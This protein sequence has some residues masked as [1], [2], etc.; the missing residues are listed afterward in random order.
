[1]AASGFAGSALY[2]MTIPPSAMAAENVPPGEV[3]ATKFILV[4]DAGKTQAM[5]GHYAP[6]YATGDQNKPDV[7]DMVGLVLYGEDGKP[8]IQLGRGGPV[9]RLEM[10]GDVGWM[11]LG[12][13]PDGSGVGIWV[14]QDRLRFGFGMQLAGNGGAVVNDLSGKE[15][16]GIG[17]PAN[18]GLSM[19]FKDEAGADIWSAP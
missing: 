8:S 11:T 17:M 5:I 4:D 13:H 2:Q 18:A 3:R 10:R 16:F 12:V 19:H 6:V 7:K 14:P 1:M 9:S 15:R